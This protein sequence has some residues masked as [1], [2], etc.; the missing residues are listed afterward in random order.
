ML[1]LR[2]VRLGESKRVCVVRE[3]V[4]EGP[5]TTGETKLWKR[6]GQMDSKR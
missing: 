2:L 3:N 5:I 1:Y 4:N 6:T